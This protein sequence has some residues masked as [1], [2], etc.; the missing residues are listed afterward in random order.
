MIRVLTIL[1]AI[2]ALAVSAAPIASAH[3]QPLDKPVYDG[4]KAA[5]KPTG[6]EIIAGSATWDLGDFA[7]SKPNPEDAYDH[8]LTQVKPELMDDAL[9][10][11]RKPPPRGTTGVATNNND[12]DKLG[13]VRAG[14]ARV[15]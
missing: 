10:A 9:K 8:G 7:K 12:P 3:L 6:G 11:A 5:P 15:I 1:A 4:L 14:G 13:K 2:A